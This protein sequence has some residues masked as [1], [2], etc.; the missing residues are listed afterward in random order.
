MNGVPAPDDAEGNFRHGAHA[1]P[2]SC[3]PHQAQLE[4]FPVGSSCLRFASGRRVPVR[5]AP[6]RVA[7]GLAPRQL[8]GV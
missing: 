3:A 1:A 8:G 7:A 6:S 2:A 5:V 4:P